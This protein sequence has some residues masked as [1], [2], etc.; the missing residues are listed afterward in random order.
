MSTRVV[1][2]SSPSHRT[3]SEVHLDGD[4]L[5]GEAFGVE[6]RLPCNWWSAPRRDAVVVALFLGGVLGELLC[7][8]LGREASCSVVG[9]QIAQEEDQFGGE[10]LVEDLDDVSAVSAVGVGT[11]P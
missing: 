1:G 2:S 7:H 6:V 3:I 4:A 8:G 10:R 9:S 11:A 5:G